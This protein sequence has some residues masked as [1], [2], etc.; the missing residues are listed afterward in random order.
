LIHKSYIV[1]LFAEKKIDKEIKRRYA[2]IYICFFC[3]KEF[4]NKSE[5]RAH[6]IMCEDRPPELHVIATPPKDLSPKEG[7]LPPE[8]SPA[9]IN[10]SEAFVRISKDKFVRAL[11]IVQKQKAARIIA[12][13]RCNS[14]DIDCTLDFEPDTPISPPTPRTPKLLISQLSK[15]DGF[16]SSR[17]RLSYSQGEGEINDKESVRSCGSNEDERPSHVNKSLFNIDVSSL[18][19]QRVVKY[20]KDD[21]NL[22]ILK[23]SESFCRTPD[24]NEYYD[25]LRNR[26]SQYPVTYRPRKNFDVAY[27]YKYKFTCK[28]R[29]KMSHPVSRKKKK[30][31]KSLLKLAPSKVVLKKLTKADLKKWIRKSDVDHVID[32]TFFDENNNNLFP[33]IP[34]L[35][36]KEC[37]TLLGLKKRSVKTRNASKDPL[38]LTNVVSEDDNAEISKQKLTVYRCLLSEI[39]ELKSDKKPVISKKEKPKPRWSSRKYKQWKCKDELGHLSWLKSEAALAQAELERKL[40]NFLTKR[41][42]SSDSVKE[43]PIKKNSNDNMSVTSLSTS[44]DEESYNP[45]CCSECRRKM[46]M[47]SPLVPSDKPSNIKSA[48]DSSYKCLR[49][50]LISEPNSDIMTWTVPTSIHCSC[51]CLDSPKKEI[52]LKSLPLTPPSA[53]KMSLSQ[54][55]LCSETASEGI[56]T[57]SE[58]NISP[59]RSSPYKLRMS[60]PRKSYP[61]F[62]LYM[63]RKIQTT[64]LGE[65]IDNLCNR[66]NNSAKQQKGGASVS[67]KPQK[68]VTTVSQPEL[69]ILRRSKRIRSPSL[70]I[71]TGSPSK[72]RKLE[73]R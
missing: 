67:T 45:R 29:K 21:T 52:S 30:Q 36:S 17:K 44:S 27:S 69:D 22:V 11:G 5:M 24:K 38:S 10:L 41:I 63:H 46:C 62:E 31:K 47:C 33:K 50:M 54:L 37:D 34:I 1:V 65:R 13:H 8:M 3:E 7:N 6:Q 43:L 71:C 73:T 49:E 53:R 20:M 70:S 60:S 28:Q 57:D 16:S 58:N 66:N 55:T 51:N 64:A 56:T 35:H 61:D 26:S 15:D 9:K 23:D 32:E 12:R 59:K 48:I 2:E 25:K 42:G 19:G 40:S 68:I 72:I 4:S 18:L 39:T 14:M